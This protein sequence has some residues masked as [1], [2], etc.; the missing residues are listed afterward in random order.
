MPYTL[1]VKSGSQ[2][3][4]IPLPVAGGDSLGGLKSHLAA[5][6]ALDKS[7]MNVLFK[8]RKL[9]GIAFPD[10]LPLGE[11]FGFKGDG[12]DG[13]TTLQLQV[14]GP[15]DPVLGALVDVEQQVS[16]AEEAIGR[17]EDFKSAGVDVVSLNEWSEKL[18][19]I[20]GLDDAARE[21]RR[22]ILKRIE[23]LEEKMKN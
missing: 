17:G 15:K 16:T 20:T 10:D 3:V 4:D 8:G 12:S 18:D 2:K 23:A 9:N 6:F 13:D 1:Q 14:L 21:R 22:S 11:A 19:A 7:K 5:K